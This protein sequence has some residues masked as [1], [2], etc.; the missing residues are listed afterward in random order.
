M[1]PGESC[2][3]LCLRPSHIASFTQQYLSGAYYASGTIS[4]AEDKQS[5]CLHV[6]YF[7]VEG[8][9]LEKEKV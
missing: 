7:P 6:A 4:M 3:R 1:A 8:G 2:C 5:L 9:Q